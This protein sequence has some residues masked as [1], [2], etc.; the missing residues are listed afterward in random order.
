MHFFFSSKQNNE[1][2]CKNFVFVESQN[3]FN[4]DKELGWFLSETL[5]CVQTVLSSCVWL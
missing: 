1:G 2:I 5:I 4:F 3:V